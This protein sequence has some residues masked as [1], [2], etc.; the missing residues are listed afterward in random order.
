MYPQAW[1]EEQERLAE[2]ERLK[3]EKKAEK[4][5]KDTGK[6]KGKDKADKDDAKALK[7]KSS[8]KEKPKEE[9]AKTLEVIEETAP[10]P[11]PEVVYP[12]SQLWKFF[13]LLLTLLGKQV[14][15]VCLFVCLFS[16]YLQTR[17]EF[18]FLSRLF[19][20]AKHPN[21]KTH[22]PVFLI[23]KLDYQEL[24]R[25]KCDRKTYALILKHANKQLHRSAQGA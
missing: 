2:E 14:L 4:K 22:R 25:W 13:G 20:I 24:Q 23:M 9:P 21:G 19:F 17:F 7:K 3:E 12:V 16:C 15:F 8:S 11:V 6:K 5:G 1:K 10:L 18:L